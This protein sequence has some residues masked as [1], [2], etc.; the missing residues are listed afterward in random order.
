MGITRLL[1][2]LAILWVGWLI[3]KRFRHF[4]AVHRNKPKPVTRIEKCEHCGL[5]VP[6]REA[7]IAQGKVYCSEAHKLADQRQDE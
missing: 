2:L 6:E 7:V 1:I 4:I 3:Y 5:H